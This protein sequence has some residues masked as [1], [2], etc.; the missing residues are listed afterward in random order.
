MPSNSLP[1]SISM[2]SS[3]DR[4]LRVSSLEPYRNSFQPVLRPAPAALNEIAC[5]RSSV[6][7]DQ[8]FRDSIPASSLRFS[9]SR[10]IVAKAMVFPPRLYDTEQSRARRLPSISTESQCSAC[11]T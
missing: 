2:K 5:K 1:M 9:R 8:T 11:P 3:Y 4:R 10:E 7:S 6:M